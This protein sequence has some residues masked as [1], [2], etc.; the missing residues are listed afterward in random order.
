[1]AAAV[2]TRE[3]KGQGEGLGADAAMLMLTE[4]GSRLEKGSTVWAQRKTGWRRSSR[5][6]FLRRRCVVAQRESGGAGADTDCG[7]G[8]RQ[9]DF[10]DGAGAERESGGAGA[11]GL[12][13]LLSI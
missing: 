5:R 1:M 10:C 8:A 6:C 12:G 3:E 13:N 7:R 11:V 9:T 2:V 4:G